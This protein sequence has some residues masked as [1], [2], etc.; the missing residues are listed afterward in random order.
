MS[1][2]P[3]KNEEI[4]IVTKANQA[5]P[6]DQERGVNEQDLAKYSDFEPLTGES[7][8]PVQSGIRGGMNAKQDDNTGTQTGEPCPNY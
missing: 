3:N 1:Q 6:A 5:L 8:I 2:Q 7:K 4:D